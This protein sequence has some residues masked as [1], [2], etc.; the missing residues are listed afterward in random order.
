MQ[1]ACYGFAPTASFHRH[2]CPFIVSPLMH[3]FCPFSIS[4]STPVNKAAL[5]TRVKDAEGKETGAETR[6]GDIGEYMERLL[7]GYQINFD[8]KLTAER[9][10]KTEWRGVSCCSP[11][12]AHCS[13]PLSAVS[14]SHRSASRCVSAHT[15]CVARGGSG[16]QGSPGR[17]ADGV[18]CE[19]A[20]AGQVR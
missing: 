18:G 11:L 8:P 19:A 10:T 1:T 16:D 4:Y 9:K 7:F 3:L 17:K 6:R 14:S 13:G 20:A 5:T 12:L 15:G 2:A